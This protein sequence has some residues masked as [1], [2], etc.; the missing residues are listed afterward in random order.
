MAEVPYK[1][2]TANMAGGVSR[3]DPINMFP[4]QVAEM[5]NTY[6]NAI[7]GAYK[8]NGTTRIITPSDMPGL[9]SDKVYKTKVVTLRSGRNDPRDYMLIYGWGSFIFIDL[10]TKSVLEPTATGGSP[11]DGE[12]D[13][14]NTPSTDPKDLAVAVLSTSRLI[15]ANKT[16]QMIKSGDD[17]TAA[18]AP[19]QLNIASALDGWEMN[20]VAVPT[21][22]SVLQNE[23]VDHMFTYRGRFWIC[24]DGNAHASKSLTTT[25]SVLSFDVVDPANLVASDALSL[26]LSSG[27]IDH[28][29]PLGGDM[30][31]FSNG[32]AQTKIGTDDVRLTPDSGFSKPYSSHSYQPNV[33]P[34][35]LH[36]DAIILSSSEFTELHELLAPDV[37][38]SVSRQPM[39]DHVK[40]YIPKGIDS[41][42]AS[43]VD[44]DIYLAK[45]GSNEIY[46]LNTEES[47]GKRVQLAW[48]KITIGGE[49]TVVSI[50]ESRGTLYILSKTELGDFSLLEMIIGLKN[51]VDGM[52]YS[53]AIDDITRMR[54]GVFNGTNTSWALTR[55]DSGFDTA[56]L[57]E[58]WGDRAGEIVGITSTTTPGGSLVSTP[59]GTNTYTFGQTIVSTLANTT[60]TL[61]DA[62]TLGLTSDDQNQQN[63]KITVPDNESFIM[64]TGARLQ[65]TGPVTIEHQD[66]TVFI[67]LTNT[68]PYTYKNGDTIAPMSTTPLMMMAGTVIWCHEQ[69]IFL[70]GFTMTSDIEATPLSGGTAAA[71]FIVG[72]TYE[73]ID[74][75]GNLYA[76]DIIDGTTTYP[77]SGPGRIGP[78]EVPYSKIYTTG[79]TSVTV[80]FS[81]EWQYALTDA[82]MITP[83]NNRSFF[84]AGGIT[85]AGGVW[86]VA[87]GWL[88]GINTTTIDSPAN[89]CSATKPLKITSGSANAIVTLGNGADVYNWVDTGIPTQKLT[90]EFGWVIGDNNDPPPEISTLTL[91]TGTS[92]LIEDIGDVLYAYTSGDLT[93]DKT[94]NVLA[95]DTTL[96]TAL[97]NYVAADVYIGKG[98]T[99]SIEIPKR[100]TKDE[101]GQPRIHSNHNIHEVT[102]GYR[103][104]HFFEVKV[105]IPG[106][107]VSVIKS[108]DSS[109]LPN[110]NIGIFNPSRGFL[111]VDVRGD[112]E[113]TTITLQNS[114]PLKSNF[115]S[116]QVSGT[117][118]TT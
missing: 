115:S 13:G 61:N 97:G 27:S 29:V 105:Y 66:F 79:A 6:A 59:A 44:G 25:S 19:I 40:G 81:D 101:E 51:P 93:T 108:S 50:S 16:V 18:T 92:I 111:N 99:Q 52:P 90:G 35:L 67:A 57:S 87:R 56:V 75:F 49:S 45:S 42:A 72:L 7:A 34:E 1:L 55:A 48:S 43:S 71:P 89:I 3:Q 21:E 38:E 60:I 114:T 76:L 116:Y 104:T 65:C 83:I 22:I 98:Y 41:M 24:T 47:G 12:L 23:Y 17:I 15:V 91:P 37:F 30:I 103:D 84:I 106:K 95:V 26:F 11:G 9:D 85:V 86:P 31:L 63:I 32:N 109:I 62:M 112:T 110:S 94:T 80:H 5:V 78:P 69:V 20:E 68:N 107:G 118:T 10:T 33:S 70:N 100:Y 88:S 28:S 102:V 46:Q 36:D 73:Y 4:H 58:G 64:P 14:R 117:R 77:E 82:A 53:P 113:L 2:T 74:Y 96:I 54:S 39:S 8:R